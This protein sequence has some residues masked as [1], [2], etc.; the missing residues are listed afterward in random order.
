MSGQGEE[1]VLES[2]V[3]IR[4]WP[5]N[6]TAH[7]VDHRPVPI[8]QFGERIQISSG[9]LPK[10]GGRVRAG[11]ATSAEECLED[12]AWHVMSRAARCSVPP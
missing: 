11:Q 6:A 4:S 10:S 2:I 3:G 7:P 12:G 1:G 9:E 5:K 8:D